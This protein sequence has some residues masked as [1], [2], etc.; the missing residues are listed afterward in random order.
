MTTAAKGQRRCHR[1]R[2]DRVA[3][4]WAATRVCSIDPTARPPVLRPRLSSEPTGGCR[5]SLTW[6]Y[7]GA[8]YDA[9]DR[10]RNCSGVPRVAGDAKARAN[11]TGP[12][13]RGAPRAGP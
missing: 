2:V 1:H 3:G 6:R 5:V 7:T 11:A 10:L 4:G 9:F 8:H 13:S 12:A